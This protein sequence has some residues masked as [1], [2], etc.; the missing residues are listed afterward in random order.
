MTAVCKKIDYGITSLDSLIFFKKLSKLNFR[1]LIFND[2]E[3]YK[4]DFENLRNRGYCFDKDN[5][6]KTAF[7][8]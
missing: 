3:V 6:E 7:K 1:N 5:F 2:E 4:E 8:F